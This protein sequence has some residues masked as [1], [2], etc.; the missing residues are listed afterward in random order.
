MYNIVKFGFSWIHKHQIIA[1][2]KKQLIEHW[3]N[4]GKSLAFFK[5]QLNS[6]SL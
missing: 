6:Q 5:D 4:Y 1:R 3:I 2:M